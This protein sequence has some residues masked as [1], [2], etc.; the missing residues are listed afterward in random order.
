MVQVAVAILQNDKGQILLGK[1]RQNPQDS[2]AGL[3]EFPGGKLE[4]GE[5][6]KQCL[7]RECL[8]ELAVTVD[9]LS[10]YQT[11]QHVYPERTVEVQFWLGYIIKGTPQA[12]VHDELR[13][14]A[15]KELAMLAYCP[16]NEPVMKRLANDKGV[17]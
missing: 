16:A 12:I 2:C 14:F 17:D 10:L 7:V 5:T 11:E 9:K 4:A 8:E 15:P 3:W 6:P 13:W 1:R